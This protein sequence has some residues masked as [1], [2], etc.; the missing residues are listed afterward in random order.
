MQIRNE[1]PRKTKKDRLA[2]TRSASIPR[3]AVREIF[4][5]RPDGGVFGR[6]KQKNPKMIEAMAAE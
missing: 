5:P 1:Q 6:V 4:L 2:N 3:I